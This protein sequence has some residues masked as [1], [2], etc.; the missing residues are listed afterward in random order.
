MH[1][2]LLQAFPCPD[3]TP[4]G[5]CTRKMGE[6]SQAYNTY[7]EFWTHIDNICFYL[8]RSSFSESTE[9]AV[10]SLYSA[11]VSTAETLQEMRDASEIMS[12]Q[13]M[14]GMEDQYQRVAFNLATLQTQQEDKFEHLRSQADQLQETQ[15]QVLSTVVDRHDRLQS[16][17]DQSLSLQESLRKEQETILKQ[18]GDTGEEVRTVRKEQQA[19]LD[20]LQAAR[21]SLAEL[22]SEQT[23]AFERA[24]QQTGELKKGQDALGKTLDHTHQSLQNLE[25]EQAAGFQGVLNN[26]HAVGELQ[27]KYASETSRQLQQSR[28]EQQEAYRAAEQSLSSIGQGQQRLG[29]QTRQL[30]QGMD[31]TKLHLSSLQQSQQRSFEAATQYLTSIAEQSREAEERVQALLRDVTGGLNRLIT[32]DYTI[33]SELFKIGSVVFYLASSVVVMFMTSNHMT[34]R[35]RFPLFAAMLL[36]VVAE[37]YLWQVCVSLQLEPTVYKTYC[38]L[39]RKAYCVIAFA[40]CC[41]A[42]WRYRDYSHMGYSELKRNQEYLHRLVRHLK[43]RAEA[44]RFDTSDLDGLAPEHDCHARNSSPPA[45]NSNTSIARNTNFEVQS[46][47]STT[48]TKEEQPGMEG[49]M[50]ASRPEGMTKN[51]FQ[52]GEG[53]PQGVTEEGYDNDEYEESQRLE[54]QPAADQDEKL[55]ECGAMTTSGGK[56]TR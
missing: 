24:F 9:R 54:G 5:E 37:Q 28:E 40:A 23:K 48:D 13:L 31:E 14:K 20:Q 42:A 2:T 47:R 3:S 18:V 46:T 6:N 10:H 29:E 4:V 36:T 55:L 15:D 50:S 56:C 19:A 32:L 1:L 35:I 11:T 51:D 43:K 38:M 30:V 34:K 45:T 33:L 16:N 12:R 49:E 17:L 25:K 7:T 8:Q 22:Q 44:E 26:I 27:A 41:L 53:I 39:L 21:D 52:R